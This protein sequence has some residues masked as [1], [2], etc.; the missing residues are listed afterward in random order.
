MKPNGKRPDR[1]RDILD[2]LL[3]EIIECDIELVPDLIA[4]YSAD[5]DASG[6]G[7]TLQT[8]SEVDAIAKDVAVFDNDVTLVD[9]DPK[10]DPFFHW[11]ANVSVVHGPLHLNRTASSTDD[12]GKFNE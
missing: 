8:G 7:Q 10:L 2:L 1:P 5:A 12:A 6:L 9:A 11:C 3:T 4:H